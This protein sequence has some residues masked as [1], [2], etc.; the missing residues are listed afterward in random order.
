MIQTLD[1]NYR[2]MTKNDIEITREIEIKANPVPWTVKDFTDCLNKDFYCLI[3]EV[4]Q[5]VSGFAIQNISFE[6]AHLLNIGIR[7]KFRKKGLGQD[8]LNQVVNA[9]K[10]MGSTKIILEVRVSNK[11]A[12]ELYN[13]SG[14]KKLSLG[15]NYYRLPDGREDALIMVKKLKKFWRFF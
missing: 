14:F 2:Y 3:Q 1:A 8:L 5:E 4:N 12:I 15:K 11:A 10:E 9:S 6:E 7:E 13:K